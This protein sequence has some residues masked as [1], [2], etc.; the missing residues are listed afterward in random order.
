M[1]SILPLLILSFAGAILGQN[2][3]ATTTDGKTVILKPDHTWEYAQTRPPTAPPPKVES[4]YINFKGDN[5][6]LIDAFLKLHPYEKGEF[7]SMA[8][9]KA[10]FETHKKSRIE[11]LNKN[12]ED[13]VVI[14]KSELSYDAES[15]TFKPDN[16]R[17]DIGTNNLGPWLRFYTAPN[18]K[19]IADRRI[20]LVFSVSPE[21]AKNKN[22]IRFAAYGTPLGN[23]VSEIVPRKIVVFDTV[24]GEVYKV[25]NYQN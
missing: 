4:N 19:Q 24:T 9:F 2:Q 8:D 22:N 20:Y 1:R 16:M 17:L 5:R 13:I 14:G 23:S 6:D 3:T 18:F 7:E 10:R 25:F 21:K 12:V 15:K 11:A